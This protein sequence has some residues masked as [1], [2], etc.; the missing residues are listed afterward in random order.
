MRRRGLEP[1]RLSAPD[2]KSGAS[3]SSATLAN[4]ALKR[5]PKN[6]ARRQVCRTLIDAIPLRGPSNQAFCSAPSTDEEPLR[7]AEQPVVVRFESGGRR[8][9][10]LTA[11][12]VSRRRAI[13]KVTSG[14][15][16]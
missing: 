13:S 1:L 12:Y 10:P 5:Y 6:E 7:A 9:E 4:H 2:P 11:R 14:Q 16:Q 8:G 3:A 15:T